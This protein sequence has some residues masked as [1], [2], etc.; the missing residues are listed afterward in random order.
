[1]AEQRAYL[2]GCGF[3]MAT[4]AAFGRLLRMAAEPPRLG[5]GI[6]DGVLRPACSSSMAVADGRSERSLERSRPPLEGGCRQRARHLAAA[7]RPWRCAPRQGRL[8][9]GGRRLRRG[10]P[11]CVPQEANTHLALGVSRC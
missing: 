11:A 5:A 1:M 4:G 9:R 6:R 3:A 7:P 8:R 10:R 2:A